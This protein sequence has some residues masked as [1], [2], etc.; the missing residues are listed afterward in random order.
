MADMIPPSL[1]PGGDGFVM[2]STWDGTSCGH[3][4][5]YIGWEDPWWINRFVFETVATSGGDIKHPHLF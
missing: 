1:S 5:L 3:V 4:D 2:S